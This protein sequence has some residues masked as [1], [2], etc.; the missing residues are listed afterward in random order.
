MKYKWDWLFN[1]HI[2]RYN[3]GATLHLPAGIVKSH[4]CEGR[5]GLGKNY[6]VFGTIW[7]TL[8][9]VLVSYHLS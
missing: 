6:V 1:G 8:S 3:E 4:H 2:Q 5:N 7:W 9:V